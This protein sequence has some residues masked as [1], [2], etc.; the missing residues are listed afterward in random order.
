MKKLY[1]ALVL[2]SLNTLALEVTSVAG[3]ACW[4]SEESQLIKIAS[5][6]D[7]KSFII[8]GGDL[9]RFQENLDRSGVQLIHDES[10]SYYVHCGSFGAQFVA[11]IKT[12]NGRAC[13][14]SRFA[15]GKFSK[16][17]VGELQ[18]V[19]LGI[20]DGYREGQLL[21]GL[22]PDEA[23]RAEAIDQ[24]REYLAGKGELIKVN[25][26]LYQVKFEDTSAFQEAFSK[27]EGVKY[28]E[29]IMINHPVGVFHQLES[30]NK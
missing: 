23:L 16:F 9:S 13:V 2:F 1:I 5:F 7:Q 8:D 6:N 28:I 26:K 18:E 29:R 15:E 20:C 3:G 27:K 19:E 24:M 22:T 17:E 30:L 14:W 11:N 4:I 21:I 25:D 10:N 12:Q